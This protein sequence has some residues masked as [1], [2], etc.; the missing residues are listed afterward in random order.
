MTKV[1]VGMSMALD[2]I[3]GPEAPDAD[4]R[5]ACR[6]GIVL[7]QISQFLAVAL[8]VTSSARAGTGNPAPGRAG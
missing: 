2:G 5:P 4:A 7:S 3:A 8:C 1:V 6:P